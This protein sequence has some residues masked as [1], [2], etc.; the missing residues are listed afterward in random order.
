MAPPEYSTKKQRK[1]SDYGYHQVHQTRWFDNDMYAHLNNAVYTH[2]F[3][4]IA[5]TYLIEH[6]GMDPFSVN[7]PTP[8]Q[9][10]QPQPGQPSA[11]A[12]GADQIGLIVSTQA[13]F[14]ASVRFPDQLEVG[15][16]VNKLSKSSVTWEVG[17]FKKGEEGVKMVGTY[18]HVFVLRETMR[19]GKGGMEGRVREGLE[20]L[21]VKEGAKL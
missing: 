14:F 21:L 9:Q 18:T 1:R 12:A 8:T 10:P 7:N 5:N 15:L 4:T 6:C 17:I 20:K 16:R 13:D 19:V 3:D 11:I 2:L